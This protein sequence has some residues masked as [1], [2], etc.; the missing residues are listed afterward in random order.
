MHSNPISLKFCV[1]D[2]SIPFELDTGAAVSTISER[3][4]SL[5]SA[6]ITPSSRVI[7]A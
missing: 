2:Q 6:K 4:A 1:N 7:K 3:C 5:L